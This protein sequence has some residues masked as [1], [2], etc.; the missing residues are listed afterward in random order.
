MTAACCQCGHDADGLAPVTLEP[1]CSPC[2]ELRRQRALAWLHVEA[3][4]EPATPE[5]AR[6]RPK[7]E[8]RMDDRPEKDRSPFGSRGKK[9]RRINA[10]FN[11]ASF[12]VH[13]SK[14]VGD[15]KKVEEEL[16]GQEL[17][18]SERAVMGAPKGS[19]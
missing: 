6:G 7:T 15:S 5:M 8:V 2:W 13:Y 1:M 14:K 10:H 11:R 12:H 19:R 18:P 16:S 4:A 9:A 3:A 17:S